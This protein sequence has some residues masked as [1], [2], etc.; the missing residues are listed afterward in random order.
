MSDKSFSEVKYALQD[1]LMDKLGLGAQTH[2]DAIDSA[3]EKNG[4]TAAVT[5]IIT[6]LES[7]KKN[8]ASKS[9]TILWTNL[10]NKI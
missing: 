5:K 9:L 7:N 1:L 4:L 8:E 10:K 6:N 3:K 2:I